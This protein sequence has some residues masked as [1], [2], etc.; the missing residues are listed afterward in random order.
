MSSPGGGERQ[1][2][3]LS[4]SW[5]GEK[6]GRRDPMMW[7]VGVTLCRSDRHAVLWIACL[8][9]VRPPSLLLFDCPPVG[10]ILKRAMTMMCK[11]GC[12]QIRFTYRV[13]STT[14]YPRNYWSLSLDEASRARENGLKTFMD[15]CS[16]PHWADNRL[17]TVGICNP[18]RIQQLSSADT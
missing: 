2:R 12:V 4:Y 7:T 3:E 10:T 13:E 6:E 9:T 1:H 5:F 15:G 17:P 14:R 8:V 11:M 18:D 16:T